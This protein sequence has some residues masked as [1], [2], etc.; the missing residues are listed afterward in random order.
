VSPS[1]K[2][3]VVPKSKLELMKQAESTRLIENFLIATIIGGVVGAFLGGFFLLDRGHFL[4]H[5]LLILFTL[6]PH[7]QWRIYTTLA[8]IASTVV[9]NVIMYEWIL[10]PSLSGQVRLEFDTK[11]EF[12]YARNYGFKVLCVLVPLYAA[13]GWW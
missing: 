2:K 5:N 9:L 12:F 11:F 10:F 6:L 4:R 3:D 1:N 8:A 7:A 13:V